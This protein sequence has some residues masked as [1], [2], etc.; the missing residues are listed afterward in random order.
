MWDSSLWDTQSSKGKRSS[1]D[2]GGPAV[3]SEAQ[4]TPAMQ[5]V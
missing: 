5:E 2:G 4:K 1:G 3:L